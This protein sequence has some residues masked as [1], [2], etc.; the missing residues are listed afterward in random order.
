MSNLHQLLAVS[1]LVGECEAL[2][3]SGDLP[4]PA[5]QSLRFLIAHTLAA[6]E[7]PSKAE[8]AANTGARPTLI[9]MEPA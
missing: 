1:A 3:A 5:E 7:M 9:I 4:P 2:A 8:M 6:F